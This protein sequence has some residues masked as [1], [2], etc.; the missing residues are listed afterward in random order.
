MGHRSGPAGGRLS[1]P[2]GC[3]LSVPPGVLPWRPQGVAPRGV[4]RDPGSIAL[5]RGARTA[6]QC[7]RA[8]QCQAADGHGAL[9]NVFTPH[10]LPG[11]RPGDPRRGL[12]GACSPGASSAG[13]WVHF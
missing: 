2:C 11:H 5:S 8:Q 6:D 10:L 1:F 12:E 4:G 13:V 3:V 9:M 7:P